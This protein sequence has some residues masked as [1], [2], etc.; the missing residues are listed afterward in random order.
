MDNAR[1]RKKRGTDLDMKDYVGDKKNP[2][3]QGPKSKMSRTQQLQSF[4]RQSE[5]EKNQRNAENKSNAF[6]DI[7]GDS[8]NE[9]L[10][11]ISQVAAILDSLNYRNGSRFN[12]KSR[13]VPEVVEFKE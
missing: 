11:E 7:M 9:L 10:L 12:L 3:D 4:K 6:N 2:F 1:M 13:T 8:N 5:L